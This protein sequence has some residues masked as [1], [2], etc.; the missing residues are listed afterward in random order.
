MNHSLLHRILLVVSGLIAIGIGAT[1]LLT[2]AQFHARQDILL[3]QDANL[4]SEIR[5]PGGALL[6]LGALMLSGGFVHAL[7]R[8]ATSVAAAVNLSYGASRLLSLVLDGLPAAGLLGAT[9][10]ELTLGLASLFALYRARR[11]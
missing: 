8:T 4:L 1:I 11:K 6:V 10:L 2:P 7:S 5:A 3:A 9:A